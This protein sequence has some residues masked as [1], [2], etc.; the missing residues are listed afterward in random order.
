M[1]S[2]PNGGSSSTADA[3]SATSPFADRSVG[4]GPDGAGGANDADTSGQGGASGAGQSNGGGHSGGSA[5]NGDAGEN[6][7][8]SGAGNDPNLQVDAGDS[9]PQADAGSDPEP[10]P[11][12]SPVVNGCAAFIDRSASDATRSL[13]W[14]FDIGSDPLRCMRIT[15]GQSVC[16][17]GDFVEHPL[18]PLGGDTPTPIGPP[19]ATFSQ[20]GT[21]GY[22]CTLHPN[23]N[24]A[25]LVLP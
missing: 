25:V 22:Y 2:A 14:D 16:W 7:G 10:E 11:E 15:V 19:C 6:N 24:G 23:M 17:D 9:D 12:P 20:S 21:Y 1:P 13:P 3:S 5:G 8:A 18:A 4:G